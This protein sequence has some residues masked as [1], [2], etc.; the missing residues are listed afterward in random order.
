MKINKKTNLILFFVIVI[1]GVYLL[2]KNDSKTPIQVDIDTNVAQFKFDGPNTSF[3]IDDVLIN[4][5]NGE[6]QSEIVPD[7]AS[8]ITTK[9]FGNEAYG[10]IDNDGRTD[11]AFLVTQNG[12]GSGTFYYVVVAL[13]VDTGYVGTN[14]VL[15]GDRIAPQTTEFKDGEFVVNYATRAFDEPMTVDPSVGVSKYLMLDQGLL[16]EVS[17]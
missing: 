14:A 13:Q 1:F 15:L 2:L 11:V 9:Y 7:S 17:K 10:D 4:L 8:Q 16:V 12:G 5:E 6:T 3:L